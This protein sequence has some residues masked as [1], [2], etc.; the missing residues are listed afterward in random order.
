MPWGWSI[1]MLQ[2]LSM[3]RT[4]F[5]LMTDEV[6]HAALILAK[7]GVFSPDHKNEEY[8]KDLTSVPAKEYRELYQSAQNRF[9]KIYAHLSIDLPIPALQADGVPTIEKLRSMNEWLTSLWAVCSECEEHQRKIDEEINLILSLR[10]SLHY[11]SGLEM[12]LQQL[13]QKK[14]FLDL[15]VGLVPEENLSRL[16]QAAGLAGYIIEVF[17]REKRQVHILV[18]GL[19]ENKENMQS[20]LHAAGY[21]TFPIPEAFDNTPEV[22]NA[23]LTKR[24]EA[25][26]AD[27]QEHTKER[28]K[29]VNENMDDLI[30]CWRTLKL[31]EPLHL[32]GTATRSRGDLAIIHGWIP[33]EQ[34]DS[35]TDMLGD[36]LTYPVH[37]ESHT[38]AADEYDRVPTVIRYPRWM[39]P[40]VTLTR[41]Y[42]TPRYGEIDP[43][44]LFAI[45]SILLFGIMF[46]DV[47]HGAVLLASALIFRKVL[48]SFTFLIAANGI[49]SIFFGF[50]Y[51]SI[52]GDEHLITPL[53]Q[54]PLHHP[55]TVLLIAIYIG[56]AFVGLAM[57]INI[58]NLLTMNDRLR[59]LFSPGGLPGVLA[60]TALMLMFYASLSNQQ[61]IIAFAILLIPAALAMMAH[62]LWKTTEAPVN[63]KLFIVVIELFESLTSLISNVLSFLRVGAFS[64]NHVALML[65]VFAMAEMLPDTGYW[66]VI[67]LG[68]LFVIGFEGAIV[69]IQVLRLEYYEGLSRYFHGDGNLFK[70]LKLSESPT[71]YQYR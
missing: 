22:L 58:Y 62:Y 26:L 51:G 16:R 65:A 61:T 1:N 44:W 32:L 45:S 57:L 17:H 11:F 4:T 36:A 34:L 41:S 24:Y 8:T 13:Q 46:G 53:W 63:E 23:E 6:P 5:H 29:R 21:R 3:K 19:L 31:I 14:T 52:F 55:T 70:P 66:I 37:V 40:F 49:S 2:A 10:K 59:A 64:L 69:M 7:T 25:L 39:M 54:S 12:N 42:G 27:R 38:P 71:P 28:F 18:A 43:S 47:G 20:V 33:E 35:V 50:V 9:D 56:I 15:Q 48:R 67:V 30:A 68:N 60:L